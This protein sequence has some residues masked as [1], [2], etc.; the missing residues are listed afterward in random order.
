VLNPEFET[1]NRDFFET[2]IFLITFVLLGRYLEN[3]AKG[4]TS[5]AI[6]KLLSL[7]SKVAIL[8][9]CT[10]NHQ[11]VS[12]QEI[13]IDLVE[14]GDILK[15]VPGA[16]IPTDGEVVFG[17]TTVEEALLSGENMPKV[18]R[19]GDK[20][21][22]GTI[23]QTGLIHIV[24]TKV[25]NETTLAQ[26]IKLVEEAH[27]T[28][29]SIQALADRI[30]GVFVPVVIGLSLVTFL[31]W[32]TAYLSGNVPPQWIPAGTNGPVFAM[33]FGISV[34]VIAC[35]CA[36]GLATPTAVMVGTGIAAKHA[37]LIKSAESLEKAHKINAVV[38]DKTGTLT[39]GK[40]TVSDYVIFRDKINFHPLVSEDEFFY[41]VG[42]AES[43]CQH[44]I[45]KA[46]V[47]YV[48][49]KYDNKLALASPQNF[50]FLP[51]LGIQCSID[52]KEILVGNRKLLS[53]RNL[54]LDNSVDEKLVEFESAGKTTAIVALNKN[55]VGIVAI[56]DS[57]RPEAIEV[58]RRLKAMHIDVWMVT[59][60]NRKTAT[61]VA[62][63]LGVS[64][65]FS[66]VLPQFKRDKVREL[67]KNGYIVA[68]VGDGINDS[69]A[70]AQADIGIAIG[71]GTDIAIEAAHVVLMRSDLKDVI[72]AIDISRKTYSRIR[73]N[74]VW[75]FVYNILG[76]PIAAGVFYPLIPVALPPWIAGAAMALS[77]VS[78]VLSSL[79][80][81]RYRPPQFEHSPSVT[82]KLL[83]EENV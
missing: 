34:L 21:V 12:E 65:V 16:S 39:I 35:P 59:G 57:L 26:I 74:F 29:S 62:S 68:M 69:P 49:E 27:A 31:A 11:I 75:A 24:A 10:D 80:L 28:K 38:F 44:P 56:A 64:N 82:E 83:V 13:S 54:Q 66:E 15:I 19:V 72:V 41:F 30:A 79:A 4:K 70:L 61:T 46:I 51:G 78:V 55:V 17:E 33:L 63:Q 5:E 18:K 73:S 6:T 32:L 40:P 43:A 37:I 48:K 14:K 45:A 50:A 22:G 58:I 71:A 8:L 76:I 47:T 77:S 9:H 53:E 67:Q 60:D 1:H 52:G 36:L 81:T 7:R 3:K 20:V 23:N 25:G 42:S 2:S